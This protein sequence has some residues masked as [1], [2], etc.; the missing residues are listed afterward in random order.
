MKHTTQDLLLADALLRIASEL[1]AK[2][3]LVRFPFVE[4]KIAREVIAER[5]EWKITL[6][7]HEYVLPALVVLQEIAD[8][9]AT[10]P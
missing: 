1:I 5:E 4:G 9:A 7:K 8:I 2:D 3:A 6:A 10:Q